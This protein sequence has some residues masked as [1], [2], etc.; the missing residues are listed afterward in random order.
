MNIERRHLL[1]GLA[2]LPLVA[3]AGT[4]H[5]ATNDLV[6]TCDTALGPAMMAAAKQ[7]LQTAHIRVHVFPTGPGLILPQLAHHIQNDIACTQQAAMRAA[8]ATG[9]VTAGEPR[10]AWRN[11]LVVAARPGA[12]TAAATQRIAV[13]DPTPGSDMDGPAILRR[14]G[15]NPATVLGVID[16]DEVAFLLARGEADSGLLHMTDIHATRGLEILLAVPDDA[17]PPIIYTIAVTKRVKHRDA[18]AFV[19]FLTSAEGGKVLSEQGL[20]IVS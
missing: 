6:L 5:A 4:A 10:G 2:A 16:T 12:G 15:L 19:E 14:L 18:P 9:L 7:F 20:E 11:R 1:Q 17:A 3:S 13:S 8:V